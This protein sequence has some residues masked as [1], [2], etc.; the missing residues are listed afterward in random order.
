MDDIFRGYIFWP[1]GDRGYVLWPMEDRKR[2]SYSPTVH[3]F[4]FLVAV[5]L[6]R[7][8]LIQTLNLKE[9]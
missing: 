2:E 3:R 9:M 8:I 7:R 6:W 1:I 4:S 5:C